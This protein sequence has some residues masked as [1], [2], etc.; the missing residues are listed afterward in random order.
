MPA[1]PARL[2]C[3]AQALSALPG[4]CA[5]LVS[6]AGI[7]HED[8]TAGG[9]LC[10]WAT[11]SHIY[12]T[13]SPGINRPA[14]NQVTLDSGSVGDWLVRRAVEVKVCVV[15]SRLTRSRAAGVI[16]TRQ[17]R[18]MY[19]AGWVTCLPCDAISWAPATPIACR[20][21]TVRPLCLGSC[22]VPELTP[23]VACREPHSLLTMTT[24][25]KHRIPLVI[26]LCDDRKAIPL[27]WLRGETLAGGGVLAMTGWGNERAKP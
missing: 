20:I 8:G 26:C 15:S 7:A 21:T 13:I 19:P 12:A 11:T 4:C 2:P 5:M 22:P 3:A 10:R 16:F 1:L 18:L 9:G 27:F 24:W 6:R 14:E 25:L 17:M 23:W